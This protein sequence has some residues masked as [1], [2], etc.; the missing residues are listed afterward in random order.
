MTQDRASSSSNHTRKVPHQNV[1]AANYYTLLGLKPSASVREIRQAY[2]DLSKLYHP[3]TTQL[4]AAIATEK[5]QKLNEAYATLSSPDRRLAYDHKI[6]Y[7]RVIV[8]QPLPSLNQPQPKDYSSSAY[9]DPTDRPLSPGE[10]F[11]LFILGITFIACLILAVTIGITRGE[12]AFQPLSAQ[13]HEVQEAAESKKL[14]FIPQKAPDI[15]PNQATIEED[16]NAEP[17]NEEL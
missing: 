14:P 3:D 11:A 17:L 12:K 2:R 6:G 4:P 9:L 13:T 7:S 16:S 15:Q 8:S 5:F 1:M 10:L